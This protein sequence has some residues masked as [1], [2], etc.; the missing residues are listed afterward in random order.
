MKI[1]SK[2]YIKILA[3]LMAFLGFSST[4]L[5]CGGEYGTPS[6]IYKAKG[7]VVSE[8]DDT[9]IRGIRAV[10]SE[11]HK[12]NQE[13]KFYGIGSSLT[14]SSGNFSVEGDSFP[15][16]RKILYLELIDIDGEKN[17]LF[18]NKLVEADFT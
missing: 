4:I 7:V 12:Y 10:L 8:T 9:P 11:K 15:R 17:G 1:I 3:A 16:Y 6:A 2:M 13:E 18:A 14:N 5:S